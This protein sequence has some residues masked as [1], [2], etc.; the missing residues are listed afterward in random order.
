MSENVTSNKFNKDDKISLQV[1]QLKKLTKCDEPHLKTVEI[2]TRAGHIYTYIYI[3]RFLLKENGQIFSFTS[4]FI[5]NHFM[6]YLNKI[7]WSCFPSMYMAVT[8]LIK[9]AI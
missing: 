3:F 2:Y 8:L 9:S 4:E 6:K 1:E 5:L 7:K